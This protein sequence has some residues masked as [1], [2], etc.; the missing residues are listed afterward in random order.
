MPVLTVSRYVGFGFIR[1]SCITNSHSVLNAE[2]YSS[3]YF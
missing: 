2:L 3:I 1:L